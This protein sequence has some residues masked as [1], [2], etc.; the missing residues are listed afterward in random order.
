M[1]TQSLGES[2]NYRATSSP[3]C[4]GRNFSSLFGTRRELI[5]LYTGLNFIH[6]LFMSRS[7]DPRTIIGT[8]GYSVRS[9]DSRGTG[10]LEQGMH[11]QDQSLNGRGSFSHADKPASLRLEA[12]R[13]SD[14]GL[15]R[16]RVDFRQS[17]TRNSKVNLT[18]IS[19]HISLFFIYF[20]LLYR[21]AARRS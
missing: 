13:E 7:P 20:G 21:I 3:P 5:L 10:S 16:C 6:T 1:Q 19:E 18:V 15:Y 14:A 17:P 8:M 4:S 2:L 12:V 11:W 9:F